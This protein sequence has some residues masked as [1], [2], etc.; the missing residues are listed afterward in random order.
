MEYKPIEGDELTVYTVLG[1]YNTTAQGKD[2]WIDEVVAHTHNYT[3]VV[4]APT[5]VAD[6]YTTHTCSICG[7]VKVDTTVEATGH[8]YDA[9]TCT[10]CGAVEGA[11][12]EPA[13]LA[14]FEFEGSGK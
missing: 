3:D 1:M 14:T 13:V 6:G 9:G 2:A 12:Q 7:D 10:A 5:C 8:S 4:T 11:S